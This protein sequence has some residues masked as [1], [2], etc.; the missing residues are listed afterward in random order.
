MAVKVKVEL[1][2]EEAEV[3]T[4][5]HPTDTGYDVKF[6]GVE[7]IVGDVIFFKT[8]LSL[9]PSRGYYFEVMPRSSISKLPLSLA[10]S[11]GIIDQ[12][13]TGE[14]LIP[15]RVHHQHAGFETKRESFPNGLVQIFNSRPQ[16]MMALAKLIIYKKPTLFQLVMR[17]KIACEFIV[18]SVEA[19]DRGSGGFGSTDNVSTV[20]SVQTKE[21]IKDIVID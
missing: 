11:V 10:N 12:H 8:G 7:K 14:I 1:L 16:N 3:P 13:Y 21:E 15:V 18:G 4:I 6:T 17:K 5:A 9:Q 20:E 19:T 2:S